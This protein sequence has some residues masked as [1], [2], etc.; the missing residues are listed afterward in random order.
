[1][2]IAAP[3]PSRRARAAV[4][5]RAGLEV[6]GCFRGAGCPA[7]LLPATFVFLPAPRPP[8]V[9]GG[10]AAGECGRHPFQGRALVGPAAV[11]MLCAREG[12]GRVQ[13]RPSPRLPVPAPWSGACTLLGLSLPRRLAGP[14][15]R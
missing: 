9:A 12:R 3:L 8:I 13:T 1:M 7:R 10:R 6:T 2:G 15:A 5:Q 11:P 4:V 14:G